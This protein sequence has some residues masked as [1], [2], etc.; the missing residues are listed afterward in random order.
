MGNKP[1]QI[2]GSPNPLRDNTGHSTRG[3]SLSQATTVLSDGTVG[4]GRDESTVTSDTDND[5]KAEPWTSEAGSD[6]S[7]S[8]SPTGKSTPCPTE[9]P[10]PRTMDGAQKMLTRLCA[11]F[12]NRY[13]EVKGLVT[14][15]GGHCGTW[16]DADGGLVYEVRL[17]DYELQMLQRS[18]SRIGIRRQGARVIWSPKLLGDVFA[19]LDGFGRVIEDLVELCRKMRE[20][21]TWE[22]LPET[23]DREWLEKNVKPDALRLAAR[24]K[25]L[26][27]D[28]RWLDLISNRRLLGFRHL[29]LV[30][31]VRVE[32][33]HTGFELSDSSVNPVSI[34]P[35]LSSLDPTH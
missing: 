16:Q 29:R 2:E 6:F 4:R 7:A 34:Q 28:R 25:Q 9:L 14:G 21:Q 31:W 24:L 33:G 18:M 15:L 19:V 20:V 8:P 1:S 10:P 30:R 3:R 17:S 11:V 23:S 5:V 22:R 26:S 32:V 27:S 13:L 35:F 12:L